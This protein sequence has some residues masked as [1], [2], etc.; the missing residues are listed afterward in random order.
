M[1]T[2]QKKKIF[3]PFE[4]KNRDKVWEEIRTEK[5]SLTPE[6]AMRRMKEGTEM[7][8]KITGN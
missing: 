8:R 3:N 6:E 7:Q 2:K 4:G 1:K 5:H